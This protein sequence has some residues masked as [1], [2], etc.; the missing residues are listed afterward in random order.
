MPSS[1]EQP[2]RQSGIY[3]N[4]PTFDSSVKNLKAIVCGATGISG[5]NTIRSLLDTPDRWSKIY[6]VSRK[7]FSKELLAFFTDEQRARLQHISIDLSSSGDDIAKSFKDAGVEADYVFYY[8]YLPPGNGKSDMD[9]SSAEALIE[10]NVPP[11][12]NFLG[13]LPKADLKPKRILLQTGGKNYGMHI[14]R[15]RQPIIE[16][17][18]QPKHLSPNFYYHQE[19][20]LFKYCEEHPE[21]KWN[22]V[23]PAAVIGAVQTAAMNTFLAY[24]VY[25]AVQAHRN[26]PL[27]FPADF[28]SWQSEYSHSTARLTGYLSEWAVLEDTAECQRFNAQDGEHISWDRFWNELGRWF[29]ADVLGPEEDES[30]YESKYFAGGRDC[31]LG[32]GPPIELKMAHPLC[33]WAEQTAVAKD[34]EE[35]MKQSNGQL[36]MNVPEA[37]KQTLVM[38]DF[39]FTFLGTLSGNKVRRFGFNGFVDTMESIFETYQDMAKLGMLPPMKVDSCKPL[40]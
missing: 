21:T 19:D 27:Q 35:M 9:P 13:S 4:L 39:T 32:Y 5:F 3:R 11:F 22:I 37:D 10:A 23:M 40:V 24:G 17:D 7:P 2:L 26:Q 14:G 16:S 1:L 15:G 31:P 8:A 29:G 28:H 20:I 25:A 12:R 36:T 30:K 18:P 34:W 38:A 6:A 33:K